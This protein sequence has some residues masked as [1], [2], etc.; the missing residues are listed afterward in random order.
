LHLSRKPKRDVLQASVGI[1]AGQTDGI[2]SGN[3][4]DIPAVQAWLPGADI[5]WAIDGVRKAEDIA[6][7]AKRAL[8]ASKQALARA[9]MG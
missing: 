2:V 9:M 8:T 4:S 7:A 1:L 3:E 6:E 5:K